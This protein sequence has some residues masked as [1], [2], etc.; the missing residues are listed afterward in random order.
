[1]SPERGPRSDY[2]GWRIV[3]SM[4]TIGL[5]LAL[6]VGIGIG[7]GLLLDRHFKTNWIVIPGT[8]LGVAAGFKQLIDAVIRANADQEAQEAEERQRRSETDTE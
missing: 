2:R 8:L 1:M 6:S 7:L 3:G 5:T 4:T